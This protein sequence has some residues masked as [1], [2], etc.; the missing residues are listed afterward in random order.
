MKQ[1]L[2]CGA[3]TDPGC[4]RELNEDSIGAYPELGLWFVAD[5]MGGHGGGDVASQV[6]AQC[7]SDSECR[8]RA[9]PEVILAAHAEV[10]KAAR[11][12]RGADHMGSTVVTLTSDDSGYDI[13]W[14]GDSRA[15]LWN[16]RLHQLT[17][18]HSLVQEYLDSRNLDADAVDLSQWSNVITQCLGP[19]NSGIPRVDTVHGT[20]KA[21]DRLLL[22]SDGL[23][24][25]VSAAEISAVMKASDHLDEQQ[26]ADQLVAAAC[27]G[28]G[29][30]NISVIVVS[31][32][33]TAKAP[34]PHSDGP[35]PGKKTR[36]AVVAAIAIAGLL[37]LLY[38]YTGR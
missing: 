16:G 32:P 28:G 15:Y 35:E 1:E 38:F 17:R 7:L 33:E 20:W 2:S 13:A 34:A 5:G 4:K 29:N 18:D 22:C 27:E 12:G 9:M 23:Y 21:G 3:K 10:E 26:L 25:E 31:A 8:D 14:V 30:D 37:L 6:V 24:N 36:M 19:A 11:E